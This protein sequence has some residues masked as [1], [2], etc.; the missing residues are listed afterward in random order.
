MGRVWGRVSLSRTPP[1]ETPPR[2]APS[3]PMSV[4]VIY[5]NSDR[6]KGRLLFGRNDKY[7]C[8][9]KISS[10]TISAN[11]NSIPMLSGTNF[12]DWK[13]NILIV[14]DCMDKRDLE[15]WERSNRM[16]IMIM[17]RAVPEAFRGTMF[18]EDNGKLFL[19]ELEKC[20]AQSKKAETSTLLAK[21]VSMSQFKVSYNTQSDKWSLNE[22]ISHHVQGKERLKQDQPESAHLATF[23]KKVQKKQDLELYCFFYKKV[24]HK[25]K[26]CPK[27]VAWRVRKDSGAT[28]E[29]S[30]SMQGCLRSRVPTD[31]ERFIFVGNGKSMGVVAIG[32]F[33]LLLKTGSYFDLEETFV[34]PSFRQNLISVSILDKSGYSCSFGNNKFSLFDIQ[35]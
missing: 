18:D 24:G 31:A 13:E 30:I 12:K 1:R 19:E 32:T 5:A 10:S 27:Y 21:P 22:L 25:K 16:S 11:V 15:K 17:K 33:R 6:P 14:L 34:V 3:R 29:I 7:T 8:G 4:F 23:S 35:I 20:F 2:P 9:A 28:T 26:D